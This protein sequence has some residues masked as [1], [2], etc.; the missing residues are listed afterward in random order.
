MTRIALIATLHGLSLTQASAEQWR[1]IE[2]PKGD[3]T[4]FWDVK[5]SGN[6]IS[7][8]GSAR[9]SNSKS[10]TFELKGA[11]EGKTVNLDRLAAS[12]N[13]SCKYIGEAQGETE[14]VGTSICGG[15]QGPW[16]V[17]RQQ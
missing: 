1:V 17:T 11:I 2:G 13:R 6:A 10:V 14:I 5:L 9:D 3:V 8:K 4:G 15:A 7:G 12:D 16:R